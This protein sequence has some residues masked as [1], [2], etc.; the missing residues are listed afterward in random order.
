MLLVFLI[1][2]LQKNGL[3]LGRVILHFNFMRDKALV[4]FSLIWMRLEILVCFNITWELTIGI[5]LS[6]LRGIYPGE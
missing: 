5:Y 4:I 3:D 2:N 6:S 1:E